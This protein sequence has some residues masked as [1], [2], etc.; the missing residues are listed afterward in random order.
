MKKVDTYL[1]KIIM[2]YFTKRKITVLFI[3]KTLGGSPSEKLHITS[4]GN[5]G[6]SC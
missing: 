5:V 6:I 1:I 3:P 2:W 4:N